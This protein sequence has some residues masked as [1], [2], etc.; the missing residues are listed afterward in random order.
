[1]D[2]LVGCPAARRG[3]I[4]PRWAE[5]VDKAASNAGLAV[6][7][8]VAADPADDAWDA[9]EP[10]ADRLTRVEIVDDRERDERDWGAPGRK[11]RITDVRNELLVA[12]RR[13]G[14]DVFLSVDSDMLLHPDTIG[15]LL[16]TLVAYDVVGG[17]AYM[18]DTRACPSWGRVTASGALDRVD[19]PGYVGPVEVV[20]GI[21]AMKPWA[22][23]VDYRYHDK[24]EDVGIAVAWRDA[25]ITVAL[26]ARVTSKHVMHPSA[27]NR[28]DQRCGF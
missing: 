20:M 10:V 6:R 19:T 16:E 5:H 28:I 1:M 7:Y 15:N 8:I 12:V 26:D 24:G 18:S 14:P 25:G 21:K 27:L 23:A 2:V 11:Q 22:Y 13:E 3:W 4:L 9:L 17:Y